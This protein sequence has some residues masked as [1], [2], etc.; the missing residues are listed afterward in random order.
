[1]KLGRSVAEG[2][3]H[4]RWLFLYLGML[5]KE[6]EPTLQ[7]KRT[8]NWPRLL[9]EGVCNAILR[10]FRVNGNPSFSLSHILPV[11]VHHFAHSWRHV[12]DSTL[13]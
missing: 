9:G 13:N 10:I 6:Q 7:L 3:C 2:F 8:P 4:L 12:S 5:Y 11:N 1:M